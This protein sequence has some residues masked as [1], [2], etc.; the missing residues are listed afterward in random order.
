M[1][2]SHFLSLRQNDKSLNSSIT[3]GG[4]TKTCPGKGG[5]LGD[6]RAQWGPVWAGWVWGRGLEGW[7]D[8]E[9]IGARGLVGPGEIMSCAGSGR[10]QGWWTPEEVE[11]EELVQAERPENFYF[12]GSVFLFIFFHQALCSHNDKIISRCLGSL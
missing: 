8:R 5:G 9:G 12:C 11:S 7:W 2:N 3:H 4:H 6:G 10:L 1:H